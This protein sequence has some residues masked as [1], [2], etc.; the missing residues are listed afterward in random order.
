MARVA[1]R[2]GVS[3]T[4]LY[5]RWSTKEGLVG[6]ALSSFR[7]AATVPDTGSLAGDLRSIL[8]HS[9]S[10]LESEAGRLLRGLVGEMFKN[11]ELAAIARERLGG[12]G[13]EP[14]DE[15]LERAVG[16]GEIPP[17]DPVLARNLIIGPLFHRFLIDGEAP[18]P[19]I[20]D[21]IIPMIVAGLGAGPGRKA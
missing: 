4:T 14:I 10:S 9:I 5:R 19:A 11:A 13:G 6:A 18:D 21:E 15:V 12:A 16:R 1:K 17:T 2:A 8:A 3:A 7:P 20:V